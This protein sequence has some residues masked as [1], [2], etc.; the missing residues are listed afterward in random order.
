V[1]R[2]DHAALTYLKKFADSNARLMRW[3]LKL[4]EFSF[5]VEHKAG[6]KIPHVDALSRHVSAVLHGQTLDPALF[7]LEQAKDKFYESLKPGTYTE[8]REY[9]RDDSGLIY[10]RRADEKHQ[11]IVPG[12]SKRGH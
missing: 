8:K 4:A 9:F 1:V 11:L 3:S 5:K 10:R 7:R 12:V 2:T 6:K